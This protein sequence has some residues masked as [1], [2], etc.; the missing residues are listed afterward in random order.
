MPCTGL[1]VVVVVV[2]GVLLEEEPE[3]DVPE[4]GVVGSTVPS[5]ID[6]VSPFTPLV[7]PPSVL[8][9]PPALLVPLVTPLVT[10]LATPPTVFVTPPTV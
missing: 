2:V 7:T 1:V 8:F 10:P 9:R 3:P 6:C 4:L 5:P